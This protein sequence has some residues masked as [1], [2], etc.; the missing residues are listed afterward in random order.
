[1]INP[2]LTVEKLNLS[3]KNTIMELIGI[4]YTDVGTDYVSAKMPVDHRTYQ[5]YGILHGGASLVLAETLGSVAANFTVDH[6][7]F[8]VVGLDINANHMKTVRSG[9]VHGTASPFH[10]GGRTQVWEVKIK[11][12]NDDLVC[13]SRITLMIVEKK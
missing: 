5:P 11:D 12:D 10:I 2:D 4:E 8:Y 6:E 3:N 7:N 9:F 1:M 13:V